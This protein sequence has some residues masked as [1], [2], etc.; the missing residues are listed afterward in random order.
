MGISWRKSRRKEIKLVLEKTPP[1]LSADIKVTEYLTT[2]EH[3]YRTFKLTM[4]AYEAVVIKGDLI[5][6]EH[7]GFKWLYPNELNTL[8]WAA[9]DVPIVELL[10]KKVY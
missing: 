8:D 10:M 2:V 5:L 7:T 4:H 9:A 1:E 3:T 6:S